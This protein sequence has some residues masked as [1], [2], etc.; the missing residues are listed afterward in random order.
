MTSGVTF[1]ECSSD[2]SAFLFSVLHWCASSYI[3]S[4][5]CQQHHTR[6]H[7]WALV[8]SWAFAHWT[9]IFPYALNMSAHQAHCCPLSLKFLSIGWATLSP[10]SVWSFISINVKILQIQSSHLLKPYLFIHFVLWCVLILIFYT[11]SPRGWQ[12]IDPQCGNYR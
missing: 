11:L 2:L 3:K 4:W 7:G 6:P 10:H 8:F 9:F 1:L 12:F 5:L